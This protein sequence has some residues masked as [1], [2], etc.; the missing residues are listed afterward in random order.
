MYQYMYLYLYLYLYLYHLHLYLYLYLHP[1]GS[2]RQC[3]GWHM[4]SE[5]KVCKRS[6]HIMVRTIAQKSAQCA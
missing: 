2:N 6:A 3:T 4:Y 1:Y 5:Q